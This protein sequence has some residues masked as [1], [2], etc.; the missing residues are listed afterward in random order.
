VQLKLVTAETAKCR[1]CPPQEALPVVEVLC[2]HGFGY[3]VGDVPGLTAKEL[4]LMLLAA[5]V[6]FGEWA[7]GRVTKED[8]AALAK[9]RAFVEGTS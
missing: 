4:Q 9:F 3:P 2:P 6:G 8:E 1:A 7:G 5:E